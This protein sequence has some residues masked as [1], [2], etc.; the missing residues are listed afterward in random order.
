MPDESFSPPLVNVTLTVELPLARVTI[1]RPAKL[2]ALTRATLDD[3]RR[4]FE[5]LRTVD[6]LRAVILTG[7]GEKAFA[8]GADISEIAALDALAARQFSQAGNALFRAIELFPVPVLCAVNGF[9]L[10][11]GCELAMACTLRIASDNAYLGQPEVKLGLIPGYG[12]TQRLARLIGR[13]PALE[14]LLGGDPI[15][16]AEALRLG[17]VNHV[18]PQAE[19]LPT[20]EALARRI[21]AN[22]PRAVEFC[23]DAVRRGL[24]MSLE[25]GL[26]FEASLFA[27]SCSTDDMKEGTRAFLEKRAPQFHGR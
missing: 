21:A 7:A 14:I 9:A 19:L 5:H 3:L 26:A 4:V 23:L 27:L 12:G 20:V 1:N 2:N 24:D 18:V 8:A 16:A 10:G 6:D 11:G 25:E 22:A 17:L 15:T 13:G